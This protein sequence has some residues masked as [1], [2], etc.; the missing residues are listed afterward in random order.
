[1]AN[2]KEK[3]RPGVIVYFEIIPALTLL[4]N[5]EKGLLFDALLTYA[6]TNVEPNFDGKLAVAW[7]FLKHASDR[8]GERYKERILKT[9]YA[10]YCS[11]TKCKDPD[12]T[13]MSFRDWKAS[14]E[15]EEE[16]E[17]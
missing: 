15:A 12:A 1:M 13:V 11:H 10:G 9:R 8:D 14:I 4:S 6:S 5:E 7:V 17:E 16:S 2:P 3:N